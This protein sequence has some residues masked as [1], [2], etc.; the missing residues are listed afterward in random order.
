MSWKCF[1]HRSTSQWGAHVTKAK[2]DDRDQVAAV[3]APEEGEYFILKSVL[4][5]AQKETKKLS[6]R[7]ILF[8]TMCKSKGKCCKLVIDSGRTNNLVSIE[9]VENLNLKK[10]PHPTPY[11]VSWLQKGHQVLV[12]GQCQV[13]FEGRDTLEVLKYIEYRRWINIGGSK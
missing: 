10:T 2:E 6:Q 7:R 13:E 5:Q 3:N 9:M 12:S 1:E 8:K 4:I 11:K